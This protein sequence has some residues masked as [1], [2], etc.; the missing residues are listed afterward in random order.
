MKHIV[1]AA[2]LFVNAI[3]INAG[4]LQS[5]MEKKSP[6]T[7][8]RATLES[9]KM[10]ALAPTPPFFE[11]LEIKETKSLNAFFSLLEKGAKKES[12][13]A[14]QYLA[15]AKEITSLK[16]DENGK[17]TELPPQI[18]YLQK[19][20]TLDF[21]GNKLAT[22]PDEISTLKN[23][24]RLRL[25]HNKFTTIPTPILKL[26][27]LEELNICANEIDKLPDEFKNFKKLQKLYFG[28]FN[29]PALPPQ[30][31]DLENLEKLSVVW[32]CVR[33]LSSKIGKLTNLKQLLLFN[34]KLSELPK[35]IGDLTKLETLELQE[36]R[37]TTISPHIFKLKNLEWLDFRN[38]QLISIP[39]EIL[40]LKN[41]TECRL[42]NNPLE[43]LPSCLYGFCE[44]LVFIDG[45]LGPEP[46]IPPADKTGMIRFSHPE[47]VRWFSRKYTTNDSFR[48]EFKT[49]GQR[50]EFSGAI[51]P[52]VDSRGCYGQLSDKLYGYKEELT[53]EC[54]SPEEV[55]LLQ[56]IYEQQNDFIKLY[57]EEAKI[58]ILQ[59]LGLRE[60]P[61][62]VFELTSLERL[63]LERNSIEKIPEEIGRLKNLALISLGENNLHSLPDS[64]SDLP[65]LGGII[66]S[67]NNFHHI[68]MVLRKCTELEALSL[69]LNPLDDQNA[70]LPHLE[71]LPNLKRLDI[72]DHPTRRLYA[73]CE[74][75]ESKLK[76]M[77]LIGIEP[78]EK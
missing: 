41:R 19:L 40:E 43:Y 54:H 47:H 71:N 78:K 32:G 33:Q 11:N 74:N 69:D 17:I 20:L 76:F 18:K 27:D 1:L 7:P 5:Y 10:F 66:L 3:G 15:Q 59:G 2:L 52:T 44:G 24:R 29:L 51:L 68:P 22:L 45:L 62:F 77:R 14:E 9:E 63:F 6:Q 16:C 28:G 26:V 36:N 46:P 13:A 21:C 58:L 53:L 73:Q 60:I 38:N 4:N 50:A 56:S 8:T 67:K 61:D 37:I 48:N 30:I 25:A 12:K 35:E 49:K 39:E 34:N 65:K 64:L 72:D 75:D 57:M 42:K 70:P 31:F 23:L 55:E